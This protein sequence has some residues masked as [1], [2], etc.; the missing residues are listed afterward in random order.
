MMAGIVPAA[1]E[2]SGRT[3]SAPRRMNDRGRTLIDLVAMRPGDP[4]W[5]T[6]ASP[7]VSNIMKANTWRDTTPERVVRALLHTRGLRFRKRLTIRLGDRRWTQPDVVFTRARVAVFVD[8]C[9]W[10]AC[11]AHGTKPRN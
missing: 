5:P 11:P 1:S 8:G 9:F 10:H 3:S 7:A 4:H 2:A 6:A